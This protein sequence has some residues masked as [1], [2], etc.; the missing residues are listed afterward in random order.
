MQPGIWL[1]GISNVDF[2]IC[3]SDSW[4]QSRIANY[5]RYNDDG[6]HKQ[7]DKRSKKLSRD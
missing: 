3:V 7:T 6:S 1:S 2:E 4:F 5:G